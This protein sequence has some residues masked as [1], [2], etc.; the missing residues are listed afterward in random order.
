MHELQELHV[1]RRFGVRF[2]FL[3]LFCFDRVCYG[4][5]VESSLEDNF[6]K[7]F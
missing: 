6:L 4:A 2:F 3:V 7:N 5:K 1:H